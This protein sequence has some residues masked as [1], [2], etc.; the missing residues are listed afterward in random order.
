MGQLKASEVRLLVIFLAT[1]LLLVT[2][3]G[4]EWYSK[5]L[6]QVKAEKIDLQAQRKSLLQMKTQEIEF[7]Q[8]RD[9][10]DKNQPIATDE[11]EA[12]E[13][14]DR[15]LDVR[16]IEASGLT[17]ISSPPE[18]APSKEPYYWAFERRVVVA[19]SIE[20]IVQWMT[21]LQSESAFRV[22]THLH[23]FPKKKKEP[24]NLTCEVTIEQRYATKEILA[25][26][27]VTLKPAVAAAPVIDPTPALNVPDAAP[28][29]AAAAAGGGNKPGVSPAEAA[30]ATGS[31]KPP[32]RPQATVRPPSF[33]NS[34]PATTTRPAAGGADGKPARPRVRLPGAKP[35]TLPAGDNE[36]SLVS[37]SSRAR[38]A[39]VDGRVIR[40]GPTP[41][42]LTAGDDPGGLGEVSTGIELVSDAVDE[43]LP[44][45]EVPVKSIPVNNGAGADAPDISRPFDSINPNAIAGLPWNQHS[46]GAGLNNVTEESTSL[47]ESPKTN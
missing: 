24:E 33:D 22:I 39:A 7:N 13:N 47:G 20:N 29:G 40:G 1:V 34:K 25:M 28:V 35:P 26:S 36:T 8:K 30:G 17:L 3:F 14:L 38:F 44:V 16:G 46:P 4:Y 41:P 5:G 21:Q 9:W 42:P 15:I 27:N 31:S 18:K 2:F 32:Q 10:L 19:G 37:G 23:L 43:A 12:K 11:Y 6:Q 45:T